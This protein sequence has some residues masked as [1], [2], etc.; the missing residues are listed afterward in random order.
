MLGRLN[1]ISTAVACGVEAPKNPF[2]GSRMKNLMHRL[3]NEESGQDL[4]KYGLLLSLAAVAGI[5]SV[6]TVAH[7]VSHAFAGAAGNLTTS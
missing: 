3:W 4:A 2:G 5:T 7:A 6:K 1:A